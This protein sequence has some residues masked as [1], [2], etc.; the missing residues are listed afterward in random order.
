MLK[1]AQAYS[2]EEYVFRTYN[3]LLCLFNAF[4]FKRVSSVFFCLNEENGVSTHALL[5][6]KCVN[7]DTIHEDLF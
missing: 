1:T 3:C 7:Y 2:C 4:H 6:G 5:Y